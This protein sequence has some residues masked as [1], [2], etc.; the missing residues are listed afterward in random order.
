MTSEPPQLV[1]D[2]VHAH[3]VDQ[4]F[5]LEESGFPA[6]EAAT[7]DKLRSVPPWKPSP[8]WQRFAI[9]LTD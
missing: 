8:G 4:A 1:Y 2:L 6:D 5:K 7:L 3:E 9:R